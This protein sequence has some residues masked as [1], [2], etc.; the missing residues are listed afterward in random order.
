MK[1]SII[2]GG[3]WGVAL[4]QVLVDNKHEILVYDINQ[5]TIDL[6]NKENKHPFFDCD[7]SSDIKATNSLQEA[8]DFSDNILLSVP[9]SV[10]RNVL[11]DIANSI[12]GKKTFINVSKGIEP[13]TSLTISQIC[14]EVLKDKID[15]FVT[16]CG[17]SHAEEVILRQITALVSA[18]NSEK[19]ALLVQQLFS[20]DQ[21]VRVYTSNDVLGVEACSSVKN[22]I[23]LISGMASGLG[24]GENARAA[25]ITRGVLEMSLVVDV[26]GG[27]R[28]TVFGLTGIGDLIVTASSLNSR[29]FQAGLKLGKG[30]SLD[31]I[32]GNSKMVVE[33]VRVT[34]SIKNIAE[35]YDIELPLISTLYDV[36]FNGLKPEEALI[37]V[38]SRK[39]K[40][41]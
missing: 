19:H 40:G 41:E 16:L 12:N 35:K 39:L 38:L 32:L 37:K 33:G 36:L 18:S 4:G 28:D 6:I 26:L 8:L 30:E 17:P 22:A 23:A 5:N 29:N 10:M 9:T 20:N 21:Y 24:H 31:S 34:K 1:V 7:I 14:E 11:N 3:S 15:G 13:E 27:K 25:L 2:G